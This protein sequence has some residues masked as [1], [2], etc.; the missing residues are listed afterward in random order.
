MR[1]FVEWFVQQP[2]SQDSPSDCDRLM[3]IIAG[4]GD[5]GMTSREIN[6][7]VDIPSDL[8]RRLLVRLVDIGQLVAIDVNGTTTYRS[9][10]WVR[11]IARHAGEAEREIRDRS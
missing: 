11:G 7:C 1:S 9:A 3:T 2:P 6:R 10:G 8:L 5:S 4:A